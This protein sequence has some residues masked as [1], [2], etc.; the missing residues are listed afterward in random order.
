MASLFRPM[1]VRLLGGPFSGTDCPKW[2]FLGPIMLCFDLKCFICYLIVL[3]GIFI[4]SYGKAYGIAQDCIV[5]YDILCYLYSI[6]LNDIACYCVVGFGAWAMSRKTPILKFLNSIYFINILRLYNLC[7]FDCFTNFTILVVL[8]NF[9]TLLTLTGG[10][11][12]K[13]L[14]LSPLLSFN[15]FLN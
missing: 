12:R 13:L 15:F 10:K 4:S 5:S 3:Y 14:K 9:F 6:E 2:P 1:P 7:C 8:T 11:N